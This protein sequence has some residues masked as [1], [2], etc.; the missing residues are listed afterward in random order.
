LVAL[1]DGV[2]GAIDTN[3]VMSVGGELADFDVD[4]MSIGASGGIRP[5]VVGEGRGLND[6]RIEPEDASRGRGE[7][8]FVEDDGEGRGRAVIAV[9]DPLVGG[10]EAVEGLA[11]A[12]GENGELAVGTAAVGGAD[13]KG[14]G[15]RRARAA[16]GNASGGAGRQGRGFGGGG[17]SE[18]L[19]GG[20]DG[21]LAIGETK[22]TNLPSRIERVLND[23]TSLRG[24]GD[25]AI[26]EGEARGVDI[27]LH[28]NVTILSSRMSYRDDERR[29][30][31]GG[32]RVVVPF[33]LF[34]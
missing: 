31:I 7:L 14:R 27:S 29:S 34:D 21:I 24:V 13:A 11:R 19:N 30:G 23:K 3:V 15:E 5:V 32:G 17:G 8:V 28:I 2:R 6:R 9:V 18:V 25:I 20:G 12:N 1:V 22:H 10:D 4:A 33:R 16:V 26:E